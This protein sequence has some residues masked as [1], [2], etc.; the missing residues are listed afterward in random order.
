MAT[1]VANKYARALFE[2]VLESDSL[3]PGSALEELDAITASFDE[4]PKFYQLYTSPVIS[5]DEKKKMLTSIFKDRLSPEIYHFLLILIDKQREIAFLDIHAVFQKLTEEYQKK[6]KVTVI[7]AV[8][9]NDETVD[10]LRQTL[11][12]VTGKEVELFNQVDDSI[13]GGAMLRMGDQVIDGTL[14]RR[15]NIMKDELTQIIV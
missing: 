8:P 7:T 14:R 10:R 1:L 15:L 6:M 3:E 2:A 11:N 4:V 13:I 5:D 9:L 12:R